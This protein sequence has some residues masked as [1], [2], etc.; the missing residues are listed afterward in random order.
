[1]GKKLA[2][3]SPPQDAVPVQDNSNGNGNGS[4]W[5]PPKEAIPV[6]KKDETL[7]AGSDSE[8]PSPQP[9]QPSVQST[10]KERNIIKTIDKTAESVLAY[11]IPSSLVSSAAAGLGQVENVF[12]YPEQK[13]QSKGQLPVNYSERAQREVDQ[14]NQRINKGFAMLISDKLKKETFIEEFGKAKER[15]DFLSNFNPTHDDGG[16]IKQAQ[17]AMIGWAVDR[18]KKG[19]KITDG[20]VNRLS[21]IND[22]IDAINWIAGTVVE[23]GVQIPAAIV[24]FGGSAIGQ[25]IGSIYMDGIRQIA[26]EKNLTVEQ[27]ID[28]G[29]DSPAAALAFGTT[30]GLMDFIGAKG[31]VKGMG[32]EAFQQSLRNRTL[33]ALRQFGGA[34]LPEGGTEFSQTL[35]EQY[36]VGITT[37]KTDINLEEAGE[38]ALKGFIGGG[39]V[40]VIGSALTPQQKVDP[41]QRVIEQE[42]TKVDPNDTKSIEKAA[43]VIEAK[44]NQQE[45]AET[46]RTD[47]GPVPPGGQVTEASQETRGDDVQQDKVAEPGEAVAETEQQTQEQVEPPK[48]S[49]EVVE[50]KTGEDS[51]K[52]EFGVR[53]EAVPDTERTVVPEGDQQTTP[54]DVHTAAKQADIDFESQAFK[55][56]SK[57]LTG[58]EHL[59]DMTPEQLDTM[60]EYVKSEEKPKVDKSLERQIQ[61]GKK[62]PSRYYER[63]VKDETIGDEIRNQNPVYRE[64]S[65]KKAIDVSNKLVEEAKSKKDVD[66]LYQETTKNFSKIPP[67]MQVNLAEKLMDHYASQFDDTKVKQL[68]DLVG[69]EAAAERG[70]AVKAYD[71]GRG[72]VPK[73][74]SGVLSAHAE[75][76]TKTLGV[77]VENKLKK[78]YGEIK[79]KDTEINELKTQLSKKFADVEKNL[80]TGQR[81]LK[82]R[83]AQRKNK[84][85]AVKKKLSALKIKTE[86]Q[87]NSITQVIGAAGWNAAIDTVNASLDAGLSLTNAIDK[88]ILSVK[89]HYKGDWDTEGFRSF[90]ESQASTD[91]DML[92]MDMDTFVK[93]GISGLGMKINDIIDS[94][95]T[96]I[97]SV[98]KKL[99]D[100]FTEELGLDKST[101]Q[102]LENDIYKTLNAIVKDRQ[103]KV[104]SERLGTEK[105]PVKTK[106]KQK[107]V[108]DQII[109]DINRG[110]LTDDLF[111]DLFADYYGFQ[112]ITPEARVMMLNYADRLQKL[113]SY[114]EIYNRVANEFWN[115]L[116]KAGVDKNTASNI[117]LDFLY[118]GA[119]SGFT[120]QS[121]SMKGSLMTNISSLLSTAFATPQA[122]VKAFGQ[123]FKGLPSGF[124]SAMDIMATGHKAED[125]RDF[126]PKGDSYITQKMQTPYLEL[127]K[128]KD[129][130]GVLTKT[131]YTF[132]GYALR[133]LGAWDAILKSGNKRFHGFMIN[134]NRDFGS[135]AQEASDI[136]SKATDKALTAKAQDD[137]AFLKSIGEDIPIGYLERRVEELREQMM[138]D[139]VVNRIYTRSSEGVLM[140]DPHGLAGEFYRWIQGNLATKKEDSKIRALGKLVGR[141]VFLIMRVPAN[142]INM[143]VDYSPLGYVRAIRGNLKYRDGVYEM[144]PEERRIQFVK[145]TAGTIA[146][147]TALMMLFDWDDEEGLVLDDDAPVRL[148]GPG[149]DK[150]KDNEGI[151]PTWKPWSIQFKKPDGEWS[152]HYSFIDNPF[153]GVLAPLAMASDNV[154]FKEFQKKAKGREY[155]IDDHTMSYYASLTLNG[156]TGFLTSQSYQ[157]GMQ[158]IQDI[159]LPRGNDYSRSMEKLELLIT[160]P[161]KTVML[162]NMYQQLYNYSKAG[163]DIPEKYSKSI[164]E[165]LAK[166]TPIIESVMLDDDVDVFGYPVIKKFDV[167]LVP[168]VIL[169]QVK[170]NIDYREGLK[171]W[172]LVHKYPEVIVKP[173]YPPRT[174]NKQKIKDE[175]IMEFKEVAGERFRKSVNSKYSRLD[176]YPPEELQVVLDG[177]RSDAHDYSR[178]ALE[179]KYY[180]KILN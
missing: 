85:E 131:G 18:A 62:K 17:K 135:A 29:L 15:L 111:T 174:I 20:L 32:K 125:Y 105:I 121:R 61:T 172:Q 27:V 77:D 94:H 164:L 79:A 154:R 39:S 81:A 155:E 84:V 78:L 59:D 152:D 132:P 36:G 70:R 147:A 44:I 88:A 51:G 30:A 169:H 148:Y 130:A 1:M 47:T 23:S 128:N 3:W 114:P 153:G 117:F 35:M 142:F 173:F 24:T 108:F 65:L 137:L 146:G 45:H 82:N 138:E 116:K 161:V 179:R 143:N 69:A 75:S 123:F 166:G 180:K 38:A 92:N 53:K 41:T 22:P 6:K 175:H 141:S 171:E 165:K 95:Y 56:K 16:K 26:A 139:K 68:Y 129:W 42:T 98:G 168:D 101:A 136:Y 140:S 106:R 112:K 160:R 10:E 167:P 34:G 66:T 97:E 133:A 11:Q 31:V 5:S 126:R 49:L 9:S 55:D 109:T 46:I 37:G 57:E 177:L 176:K 100:R 80:S 107:D 110:A 91:L 118:H 7:P 151:D 54:R 119:L 89:Q 72:E 86:G 122:A 127:V 144:T 150:W 96:E 170:E 115:D 58:K 156:F 162:P 87:A 67:L 113:T 163:M 90:I 43:G 159:L 14:I 19:E 48:L 157:Q 2:Q 145:A 8:N 120:T 83:I 76:K 63:M 73:A 25:E 52:I 74:V 40:R 50:T 21:D 103:T 33:T 12:R 102:T 99:S 124:K 158:N 93:K 28:Q 104:L 71:T 178:K 134:Y 13:L 60:V 4:G 64:Q 149:F